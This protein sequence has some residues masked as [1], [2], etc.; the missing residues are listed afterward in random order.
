MCNSGNLKRG[1]CEL[2]KDRCGRGMRKEMRINNGV[3]MFH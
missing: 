1:G 3:I 2:E